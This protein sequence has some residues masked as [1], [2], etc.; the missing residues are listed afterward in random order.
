MIPD[1]VKMQL[2]DG[3]SLVT[4][5]MTTAKQC[6]VIAKTV[7][8]FL[9]TQGGAIFCGVDDDGK[10]LGIDNAVTQKGMLH[11]FLQKKIIPSALFSVNHD[12]ES[13]KSILSIEV[14]VGKD[15]PYVYDGTVYVRKGT[16]TQKIDSTALR[17]MI[18]DKS[19]AAERWERRLSMAMEDEDL[20]TAEITRAVRQIQDSGRFTFTDPQNKLS[21]LKSLA[22]YTANGFSQA[23]DVLF[24]R[25]PTLRHPQTR[26][27][28]TCY[29]SDKGA[30]KYIDDKTLQGPL[31]RI[32]EEVLDF[33]ARN[34]RIVAQF[35]TSLARREDRPEYPPEALREGLVNAF[36][37]RDY[38]CFS[39]GVSVSI[40][41]SHIEI[42]NSGRLPEG[43][44]P[45]DLKKNHPSLPINPDIAHV[46]HLRGFM[47]RI[48]RGTQKIINSC[49]EY[50]L[51]APTWKDQTTGV[52]LTLK[53]AVDMTKTQFAPNKRQQKL[54]QELSTGELIN[55][56][57]YH[58][59]FA[60]NISERQ[61]RR[62]LKELED[63]GFLV[64]VGGGATTQ[65]NSTIRTE[66]N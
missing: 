57:K 12:E 45:K 46:L 66:E 29:D 19:I 24:S 16:K 34:T 36:A 13:D 7:C 35:H 23:A 37:H 47:E 62:D 50:N 14:P 55:P 64:R 61:S 53:S 48:G 56:G 58:E 49:K 25:N 17:Q 41:P 11:Q 39:G 59:R 63:F 52:T 60:S 26:V 6:D 65:Y 18:Q 20:D 33:V 15:C 43:L 54:L 3:K 22:L 32:L 51:P 1:T 8:S 5:F 40:Y 9:N 42:W 38:A 44:S 31:V 2:R 21:I 28:V 4:E 30:N 27:R 10:I